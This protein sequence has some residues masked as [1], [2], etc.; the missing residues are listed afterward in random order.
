MIKWVRHFSEPVR[1]K[2]SDHGNNDNLALR[3]FCNARLAY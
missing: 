1:E 2:H 3:F